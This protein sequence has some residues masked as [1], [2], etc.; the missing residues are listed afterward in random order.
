MPSLSRFMTRLLVL[1]GVAL[2]GIYLLSIFGQPA[3]RPMT[4]DVPLDT[5]EPAGFPE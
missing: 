3:T 2:A 4:I 1:A 5:Q